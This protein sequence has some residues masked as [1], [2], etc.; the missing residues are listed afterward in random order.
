MFEGLLP[1]R[2]E[3]FGILEWQRLQPHSI[4]QTEDCGVCANS[5]G[6]ERTTAIVKLGFFARSR[7]L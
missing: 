7:A 4:D 6:N 3:P 1:Q 2:N 5:D